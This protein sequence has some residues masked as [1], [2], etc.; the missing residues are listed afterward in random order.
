MS[1]YVLTMILI[2][3]WIDLQIVSAAFYLP[4]ITCSPLQP[5]LGI[6][7]DGLLQKYKYITELSIYVFVIILLPGNDN[8]VCVWLPSSAVKQYV[9]FPLADTAYG[10]NKVDG[11]WYYFDDSS[12][13]SAT[14]DQIVVRLLR[15]PFYYPLQTQKAFHSGSWIS[16]S[17]SCPIWKLAIASL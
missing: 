4:F 15:F 17:C 2:H 13:S 6:M 16:K 3:N 11:K 8:L 9:S 14:E 5:S 7:F 1:S 10:K 12:V